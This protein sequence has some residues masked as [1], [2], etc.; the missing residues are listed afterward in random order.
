MK[1]TKKSLEQGAGLILAWTA[2]ATTAPAA[3]TPLLRYRNAPQ[4][5]NVYQVEMEAKG[6]AGTDAFKGILFVINL[7]STNTIRFQIRGTVNPVRDNS[8]EPMRYYGYGYGYGSRPRWN[9][10]VSL[11]DGVEVELDERGQVLRLVGDVPLPLPLGSILPNLVETL[12]PAAAASWEIT[13]DLSVVDEPQ[14]LGPF[15]GNPYSIGRTYNYVYGSSSPPPAVLPVSRRSRYTV[16][17]TDNGEAVVHKEV[18]IQSRLRGESGLRITVEGDGEFTFDAGHGVIKK[19]DIQ[20]QATITTE[21][22][23]RRVKGAWH[24]QLL[25]GEALQKALQPP[26]PPAPPAPGGVVPLSKFSADDMQ[27]ILT[28]LRSKDM[29]TRLNAVRRL[30]TGQVEFVSPEFLSALAGS[31]LEGDAGMQG[32]TAELL[33]KFGTKTEVPTLIK[34]I[35]SPDNSARQSAINGLGRIKD[36]RSVEA[37]ADLIA[38][39]EDVSNQ[40]ITALGNIGPAAEDA[41]LLLLREKHIGTRRLACGIL[42][43]IGTQKSLPALKDLAVHSDRPLSEA[44]ADAVR[45]IQLRR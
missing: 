45:T 5:T 12:A 32:V 8:P 16:K 37:L 20:W 33:G 24:S 43:Q 40:A 4:T 17:E 18:Q 27:Q 38:T 42:K 41:V 30:R 7:P 44:A 22:L 36:K 19:S 21:A 23:S 2:F 14:N 29:P 35:R 39:G 1:L 15:W 6:D 10:P 26:P 11:G 13:E 34:F 3:E 31:A 28:D 25:T 9:I